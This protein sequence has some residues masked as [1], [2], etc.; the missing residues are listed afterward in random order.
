MKKSLLALLSI[1]LLYGEDK[2]TLL[3]EDNFERKESQ[4]K[5][6]EIDKAIALWECAIRLCELQASL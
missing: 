4:E 5:T 2:A 6:E 1:P 3:F